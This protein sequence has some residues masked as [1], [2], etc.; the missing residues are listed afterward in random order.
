MKK[1]HSIGTRAAYFHWSQRLAFPDNLEYFL[2]T[3]P[4]ASEVIKKSK[5]WKPVGWEYQGSS[6]PFV[7]VRKD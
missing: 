3:T 2:L 1:L 6:R 5:G 4:S 7:P